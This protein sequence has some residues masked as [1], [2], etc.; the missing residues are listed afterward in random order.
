MAETSSNPLAGVLLSDDLMWIS[1][2][3]STAHSLGLRFVAVPS[4][5]KLEALASRQNPKCVILELGVAKLPAAEIVDRIRTICATPPRFVA[6]GSHVDVATLQ[7]AR[8]A[9]CD[10][11]LPRSKMAESLSELLQQW[12]S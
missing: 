10:P 1:R 8:D 2:V 12:M 3:T 11:V 6:F 4:V 9:G 5:E 7:S